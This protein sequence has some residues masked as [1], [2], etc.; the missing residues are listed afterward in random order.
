MKSPATAFLLCFFFGTLGIHRFYLGKVGTGVLMLLTGGGLG[1]WW[2]ID[3]ITC[4]F[5][6]FRKAPKQQVTA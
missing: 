2:F 1:I 3:L 5:K 6:L 4:F